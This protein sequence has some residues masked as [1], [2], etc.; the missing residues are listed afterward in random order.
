LSPRYAAL[1]GAPPEEVMEDARSVLKRIHLADLPLLQRR[2]PYLIA[3]MRRLRKAEITLRVDHPKLG[4]RTLL[5]RLKPVRMFDGAIRVFGIAD[6]VTERIAAERQR[7]EEAL[8][9][10]DLLVRE[11]HHRIKNNLQGVAGLLQ[12]QAHA[13]PEL[14]DTLQEIAGQIQAIAQVHGLQLRA[15][16]TL[17]AIG[18]AQGIFTNLGGMFSVAVNFEPPSPALW[19][20]G[21]PEHEA[22]P[23]ALV[24]N[25]LG[26][27]AIKY[28][29]QR[30]QGIAVRLVPRSDGMEL[31]I[32]NVG[33]LPDGF[34]LA[35]IASGVSGLGLVKAL[36]PRRGARLSL[37]Q[38]GPLVISRLELAT[39]ALREE[40]ETP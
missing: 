24:I 12:H 32:E 1:V 11:V 33:R 39:P 36:L 29:A 13:K 14:A 28:R 25:E 16:G 8:K 7:L 17:P 10:R 38:L 21:L 40:T 3:S 23:L 9:Q 5:A 19:R 18:V 20:W 27:N 4:V 35:R 15:T 22:V 30:D 37:E 31:R 6:D 26:T 34:D 2:M